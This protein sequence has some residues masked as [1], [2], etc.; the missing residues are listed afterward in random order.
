MKYRL[1][2]THTFHSQNT[3]EDAYINKA[4]NEISNF[5]KKFTSEITYSQDYRNTN[6]FKTI[7][8]MYAVVDKSEL[9]EIDNYMENEFPKNW[10]IN[11]VVEAVQ[12][13]YDEDDITN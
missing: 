9:S 1:I 4:Y 8:V 13:D 10:D 5:V 12:L 11:V 3:A 7:N 2:F 6:S